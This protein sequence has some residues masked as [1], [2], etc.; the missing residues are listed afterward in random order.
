M[1]KY[2]EFGSMEDLEALAQKLFPGG[3]YDVWEVEEEYL[4]KTAYPDGC[5]LLLLD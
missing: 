5:W 1:V 4:N 2:L 3:K